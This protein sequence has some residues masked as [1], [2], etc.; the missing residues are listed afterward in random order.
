MSTFRHVIIGNSAAGLNAANEIRK[1]DRTSEI[2]MLSAEDCMAYSP[3]VL[4]Y[5]ISQKVTEAGMYI[6]TPKYYKNNQIDLRLNTRAEWVDTERQEVHLNG[7]H[8]GD[9]RSR[10]S[11]DRLLIATGAS[12]RKLRMDPDML[13]KVD[14]KIFSL[15]TMADG[16]AILGASEGIRNALIMGAGLVGLET[17]Y[18][19]QKKG[20]DVTIIAKSRQIL[21]RN[22]DAGCA[23]M[24]QDRI[25]EKGVR[26]MFGRD[27]AAFS[28]EKGRIRVLTDT[29]EEF[30]VDMI[31]VG[32]GVDANLDL[33]KDTDIA[34]EWGIK[35]NMEMQT[36]VPGVYAAGDVAQS[37]H[38]LTGGTDTFSNWPS[39]C[40]EGKIAGR[41]MVGRGQKL[42]GEVSYNVMPVF[43]CTA[44]FLERRDD[45]DDETELFLH[46]DDRKGVYRKILVK[47]DRIVGAVMLG[48]YQDA[49]VALYLLKKRKDV[50]HMKERMANGQALWGEMMHF[51]Q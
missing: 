17:A 42:A 21:S 9:K 18:A 31:V 41:N 4:P 38:L 51:R 11:Y 46:K 2:V 24:I 43:D 28:K 44:A 14:D 3:V 22:S 27:V 39:A 10:L 48:A 29:H 32:K 49:G 12:A 1:S 30:V 8:A 47:K 13:S 6:T 26:F 23:R 25:E 33:V 19:L 16:K 50:S 5:L 37:R 7:T 20:V 45:G 34:T 35:V 40:F 36:T 15:R